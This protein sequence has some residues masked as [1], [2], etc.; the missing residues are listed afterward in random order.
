MTALAAFGIGLAL[1]GAPGAVQALLLV[2]ST[3]GGVGRG[4]KA[5]AGVAATFGMILL[6]LVLG[7][8]ALTLAPSAVRALGLAG[9][10]FLVYLAVEGFRSAGAAE[11]MSPQGSRLPPFVRGS[12]AIIF[13]P[14]A[15]L[16]SATVAGPLL[17][18]VALS[19]GTAAA[20]A[21]A[22]SLLIGAA[23][24]DLGIV[25]VAGLGLR[26]FRERLQWRIRQT[27]ACV[28]GAFAIWLIGSS[29]LL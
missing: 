26:R 19:A 21:A 4:L 10:M 6:A 15:W 18:A 1:A 20:L 12:L 2:E 8:G 22:G 25:V 9:G 13:N 11:R 29:V 28:L 17:R 5:W 27:L 23:M 7:V 14:G 24:G 3:R 16:F